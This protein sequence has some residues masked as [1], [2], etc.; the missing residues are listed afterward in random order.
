MDD[1]A[2]AVK[3]LRD[4]RVEIFHF[5]GIG[6]ELV[7]HVDKDHVQSLDRVGDIADARGN[8]GNLRARSALADGGK[9]LARLLLREGFDNHVRA[10]HDRF[11]IRVRRIEFPD[12]HDVRHAAEFANEMLPDLGDMVA[13]HVD[14]VHA[15]VEKR[16]LLFEGRA[17]DR[18]CEV[19]RVLGV[20]QNLGLPFLCVHV[21]V[22][23]EP[24]E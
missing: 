4:F 19:G 13:E 10:A 6:G 9:R 22:L 8:L 14:R 21:R 12:D 24:L 5:L 18:R 1:L 15:F 23:R 2:A 7:G 11:E 3:V 17:F 20:L 16:Y